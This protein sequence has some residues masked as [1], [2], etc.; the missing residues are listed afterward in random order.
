MIGLEHYDRPDG[1]VMSG[2]VDALS[3]EG[4]DLLRCMAMADRARR[5]CVDGHGPAGLMLACE[6]Y[7]RAKADRLADEIEF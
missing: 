4:R 6:C 5:L 1:A 2:I 7:W 3:A